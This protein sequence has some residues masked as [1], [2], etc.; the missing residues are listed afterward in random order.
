MPP[1]PNQRA[2]PAGAAPFDLVLRAS[3][4]NDVDTMTAL[5]EEGM[6]PSATNKIGQTGLHVAAIWGNIEVAEVLIRYGADVNAQNQFGITPLHM[7]SQS[8]KHA[9]A[10]LLIECGADP[11]IKAGNGMR[12][13]EVAK[14]QKM[15]ELCGA[16]S[17]KAHAAVIADDVE[18]LRELLANGIELSE[19]DAE[20]ETPLHLAVKAALGESI[21]DDP[22]VEEEEAPAANSACL[23]MILGEASR[24]KSAISSTATDD[25][26]S[27]AV[28]AAKQAISSLTS[29]QSLHNAQGLM[30]I[31]IAAEAGSLAVCEKLLTHGA[32]VNSNSLRT[33]GQH[34]GQW[35]KKVDGKIEK[36]DNT[37]QTALHLAVIRMVEQA[38]EAGEDAPPGDPSL[39]RL[40][41]EHKASPNLPNIECATPLHLALMGGLNEVVELLVLAKADLSLGCKAFGKDNTALHQA[42][43]LR[44]VHTIKLLT[45][46]GAAVDAVG[47]DGWT[48]LGLAVRS[49]AVDAAKAL[50]E[51][52]ADVHKAASGNGKTPL[53]IASINKKPE[54]TKLLEAAA[55]VE[56]H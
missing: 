10:K 30:P 23:E 38:E 31:H 18:L 53:E 20:G 13:H 2:K 43:L 25:A 21:G 46:Y 33:D 4:D 26:M 3:K 36:L 9:V 54:I 52:K 45:K 5:L 32:P 27:F 11:S 15:R 39:V 41:L 49:N 8:S 42:T 16:P 50:L 55:G 12:A 35:G 28:L 34:S 14:D 19:Q 48:P 17:L 29:A 40:L 7:A 24:I 51:A 1:S 6:D 47:R 44:N 56:V 22:L 37:D